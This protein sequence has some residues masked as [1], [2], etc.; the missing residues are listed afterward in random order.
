M[1]I[2]EAE[3]VEIIQA[4][5]VGVF[6]HLRADTKLPFAD[7]FLCFIKLMKTV[8]LCFTNCKERICSTPHPNRILLPCKIALLHELVTR[9]SCDWPMICASD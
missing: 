2:Q 6:A 3:K 7:P 5:I 9:N 8:N 1:Q 4:K